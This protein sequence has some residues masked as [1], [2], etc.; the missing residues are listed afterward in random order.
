MMTELDLVVNEEIVLSKPTMSQRGKRSGRGFEYIFQF[1]R[2]NETHNIFYNKT[3]LDEANQAHDS[4]SLSTEKEVKKQSSHWDFND[5]VLE[6]SNS[7]IRK[8]R[9]AC[10]KLGINFDKDSTYPIEVA[11]IPILSSTAQGEL[12]VD[13][14]GGIGTTALVAGTL[15]RK[16]VSYESNPENC[17]AAHVLLGELMTKWETEELL[18]DQPLTELV[19][20]MDLSFAA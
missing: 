12:V 20:E 17:K 15:K 8:L 5:G 2:R 7:N 13:L 11:M 19:S 3:W 10:K 18:S 4:I 1:V 14:F 9:N 16:S 6:A